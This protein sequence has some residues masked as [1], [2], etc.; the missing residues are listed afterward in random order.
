M[1]P[2]VT[3]SFSC[4]TLL[5][6]GR[7]EKIIMFRNQE[8]NIHQLCLKTYIGVCNSKVF[9]YN[10]WRLLEL[11]Q[12]AELFRNFKNWIFTLVSF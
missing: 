7:S 1:D 12:A 11:T 2:S 9:Y 5:N 6:R 10:L 4:I 3:D 8:T